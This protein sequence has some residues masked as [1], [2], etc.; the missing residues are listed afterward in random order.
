VSG[1]LGNQLSEISNLQSEPALG[2][3]LVVYGL[4]LTVI[5]S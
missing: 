4:L 5:V 3:R 2:S 1:H